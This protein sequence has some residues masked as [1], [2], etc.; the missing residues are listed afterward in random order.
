MSTQNS[1]LGSRDGY[2]GK[3]SEAREGVP[4]RRALARKKRPIRLG[5]KDFVLTG[6]PFGSSEGSG[7]T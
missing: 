3:G 7:L 6:S 4:Q 5:V 2:R 1:R